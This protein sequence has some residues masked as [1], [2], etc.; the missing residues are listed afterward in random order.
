[1]SSRYKRSRLPCMGYS[2]SFVLIIEVSVSTPTRKK[3]GGGGESRKINKFGN[4]AKPYSHCK[5]VDKHTLKQQ[6]K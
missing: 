2:E 3:K 4:F 6:Q 1:M 5:H